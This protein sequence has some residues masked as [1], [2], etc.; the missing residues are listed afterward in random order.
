MSANP[1]QNSNKAPARE[2]RVAAALRENL[3][4]RKQ[5]AGERETQSQ[6]DNAAQ[7]TKQCS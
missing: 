5:Q 1:E 3:R 4:K 7:S 2:D 6:S